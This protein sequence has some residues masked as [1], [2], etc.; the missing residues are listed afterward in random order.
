MLLWENVALRHQIMVLRAQGRRPSLR[1]VDRCFWIGLARYWANW[2]R[3][4]LIVRPE[5]VVRWHRAGFRRYWTRKSRRGVGRP[6]LSLELAQLIGRM[7]RENPLWGAPRIHGEL[8]K[9]GFNVAESTVSKYLSRQPGGARRTQSWMTF[10]TNHLSGIAALDFFVVPTV[11]FKL[12]YVLVVIR[13]D[14]RQ[15]VHVNVTDHPT[16]AWTRQQLREAFP[17]DAAPRFLLRD[18]DV[19]Y[20][21]RFRAS[22]KA[23][24]IRDLATTPRSP[25]Q[26]PYVERVIGSIRRECLDHVIIVNRRQVRRILKSYLSYYHE[27][28]THLSLDKDSPN[29]RP[30]TPANGKRLVSRPL[31]GGL[32]HEYAPIAA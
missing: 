16:E 4:L 5:T 8:L 28:R 25:W 30:V 22:L 2:R 24:G 13:H 18:N 17:W 31:V 19:I 12:L 32:H 9:L 10:L 20:G 7:A 1:N 15:I 29:G 6:A 27:N 26:N 3:A 23:F 14:R 11:T 21:T